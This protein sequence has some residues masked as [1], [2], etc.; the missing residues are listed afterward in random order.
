VET[1]LYGI[2]LGL[3][4]YNNINDGDDND[5]NDDNDKIRMTMKRKQVKHARLQGQRS[6]NT[7]VA[8]WRLFFNPIA[9]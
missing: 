2:R 6:V 7:W 9:V 3:L 8:V 4:Q 5:A 1:D